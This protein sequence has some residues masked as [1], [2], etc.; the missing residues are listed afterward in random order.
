M[1]IYKDI[2]TGDEMF[3]DSNKIKLVDDVL[4]EVSCRYETRKD[5]EIVLDGANPSAEEGDDGCDENSV[6]GVDVVLNQRL[7]EMP[8]FGDKKQYMLYIKD[9]MKNVVEKLKETDASQVDVFKSK[10]SEVVKKLLA[11]HKDMQFFTGESGDCEKGMVALLEYRDD[12][13]PVMMFFK[14]GLVQEKY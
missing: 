14:H 3:T 12:G 11:R 10:A 2:F 4:Y 8:I 5:G 7:M 9:Y 1:I 13:N 6:S